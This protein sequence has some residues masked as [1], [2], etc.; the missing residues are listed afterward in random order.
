MLN[1]RQRAQLRAL[2]NPLDTILQVGKD[3]IT[4]NT[5]K[6]VSDALTARELIKCRVLD[7]SGLAA[8]E[9]AEALATSCDADVVQTIGSRFV[10]YRE[11][12]ALDKEKRIKLVK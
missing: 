11:N 2:A 1:S 9:A 3:G 10:L 7:N 12:R 5:A 4:E 6:S 8:R